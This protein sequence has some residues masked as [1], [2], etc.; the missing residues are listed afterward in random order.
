MKKFYVLFL[1]LFVPLVSVL[2]L[3]CTE[4]PTVSINDEQN[5]ITEKG[6]GGGGGGGHTT[7]LTNNL[8]FPVFAADGF[9]MTPLANPSFSNIYLGPYTGLTNEDLAVL[10]GS[11]WYA[12]KVENNVWQADFKMVQGQSVDVTFVDWG[13]A[14]ESIDPK[15]G[16]P[17]RLELALYNKLSTPMEAYTMALL[18]FPSSP[19]ETQG[20]NGIKYS[21]SYATITSPNGKLVVQKFEPAETVTPVW[22]GDRWTG[23]GIGNPVPIAFAPELNVGGKYIFGAS[24]GGWTPTEI[25]NYRITFYM[26][27]Y[28]G[29]ES[30]VNLGNAFIADNIAPTTP[31]DAE[32]NQPVVDATYKITYVDVQATS[33]GGAGG[34]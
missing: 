22:T 6:K 15:I 23:D 7:V 13:D 30:S 18:A 19:N 24:T 4:N 8:S 27:N 9:I 26:A 1:F 11:N 10:E 21:S 14:I 34:H 12:Q 33:G 25:G 32:N 17:Y 2:L 16:R 28:M 3:Q 20:T 29:N 5:M 31:K